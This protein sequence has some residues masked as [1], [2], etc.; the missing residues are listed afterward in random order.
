MRLINVKTFKQADRFENNLIPPYAI[1]S[2]RWGDNELSYK[3]FLNTTEDTINQ[4]FAKV[5]RACSQ[6]KQ[7]G[8]DWMW[9]DTCCIDKTS[10]TELS[11]SINSMFRWYR[12]AQVCFAY[13]DDVNPPNKGKVDDQMRKSKWFTRGWTLQEMLASR[14]MQFFDANWAPLGSRSQLSA[15]ISSV[16]RISPKHL[17]D[18]RGASVAQKM[19]WMADRVTTEEEDTAYCMLGIFDLNMDLR[20]GEGRK[21]FMRLQEMIISSIPDESI[22]AWTT[23]KVKYSGLLAPWPDCFR[24]SGDIVLRPENFKPREPYQMTVQGLRFPAPITED[25]GYF[26]LSLQCW[27][28]QN[29][30]WMAVVV[31]LSSKGGYWKRYKCNELGGKRSVELETSSAY[32]FW[33]VICCGLSN[34]PRTLEIYIP[35]RHVFKSERLAGGVQQI[36]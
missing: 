20:Y 31:S 11:M 12:D 2:H 15:V 25:E 28:M 16:T 19:S 24:D 10:S 1:L 7:T 35:Q 14:D 22:F 29:N 17:E 30:E 8:L 4:D 32:R 26:G 34:T 6:A 18:F 27:R 13:L 9:I 5:A 36:P 33:N 23:D 3:D 21:A